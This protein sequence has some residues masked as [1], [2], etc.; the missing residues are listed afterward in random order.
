MCVFFFFLHYKNDI[1]IYTHFWLLVKQPRTHNVKLL[2]R[3]FM[4]KCM[5]VS[6]TAICPITKPYLMFLPLKEVQEE[7]FPFRK[8][9]V[10]SHTECKNT[11]TV[12]TSANKNN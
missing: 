11:P 3:I 10:L 12:M 7:M 5:R 1:H 6:P 2:M 4:A 8:I 9:T